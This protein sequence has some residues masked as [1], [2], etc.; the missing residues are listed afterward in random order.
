MYKDKGFIF[1]N[2]DGS[3]INLASFS[4]RFGEFI[5]ESNLKHIRLH[6]LR[7][8]DATM[9]LPIK[10]TCQSCIRETRAFKRVNNTR[11]I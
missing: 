2:E 11:P 8:T 7:H 4:K 1:C 9:M 10:S 6:D 5:K 3:N